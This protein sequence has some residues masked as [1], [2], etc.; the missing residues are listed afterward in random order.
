MSLFIIKLIHLFE[1][2]EKQ[3]H[4]SEYHLSITIPSFS[5][6]MTQELGT[7]P[8]FTAPYKWVYSHHV[9]EPGKIKQV[10]N[11]IHWFLMNPGRNYEIK[12]LYLEFNGCQFE[13]SLTTILIVLL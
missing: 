2:L 3:E 12:Q 1:C 7:T 9:I 8:V 6:Q 11:I 4:R 10:Q 5:V 13:S